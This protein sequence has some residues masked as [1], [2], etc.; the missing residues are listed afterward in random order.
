LLFVAGG[1]AETA[2]NVPT[3]EAPLPPLVSARWI[4]SCASAAAL[5]GV[6]PFIVRG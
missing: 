2:R 4:E 6:A 5:V 3:E 1:R